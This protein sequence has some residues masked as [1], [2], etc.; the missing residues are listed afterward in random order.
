MV[1]ALVV[2]AVVLLAV[3]VGDR[4][5]VEGSPR[6]DAAPV[7][8]SGRVTNVVDADTIDLADGTRIRLAIVDAPEVHGGM[9]PCGREASAFTRDLVLGEHVRVWRPAN[10]PATDRYDRLLGEVVRSD[11]VSLNVALAAAGLGVVDDRFAAEDPDLA[12]RARGAQADAPTPAC[13]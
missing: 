12:A 1:V 4:P 6:G 3:V 11:G 7:V 8:H 10:A 9:E 2:A 5:S 13:A